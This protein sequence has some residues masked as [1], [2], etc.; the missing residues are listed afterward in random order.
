MLFLCRQSHSDIRTEVRKMPCPH[1]RTAT[2]LRSQLSVTSSREIHTAP[3]FLIRAKF[4]AIVG[5]LHRNQKQ[6]RAWGHQHKFALHAYISSGSV[7]STLMWLSQFQSENSISILHH[8]SRSSA[9]SAMGKEVPVHAE[10]PSL[11]QGRA[12]TPCKETLPKPRS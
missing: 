9:L 4:D 5:R 2:Q 1:W 10:M 6:E 12:Q 8:I 3:P 7:L 11:Q